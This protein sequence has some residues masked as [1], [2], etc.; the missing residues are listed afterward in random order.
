MGARLRFDDVIV[1]LPG[2]L[3]SVLYRG[4]EPVWKPPFRLGGALRGG[5]RALEDLAGDHRLL[6]DPD[7][8]DGVVATGLI[9]TPV[10]V[11]GLAKVNQYRMLR[12]RITQELD[13]VVGD[14]AVD[15]PPANY[16]EFPYDWRRDNR[17][18]AA[19]LKALVDRELPKW[20]TTR[21]YGPPP[22]VVLV[23]HSMGGLVAK[24]YLDAL[25]GW[26]RCR[27][28]VT[29]GTP[30]RG[31][32]DALGFLANGARKFGVVFDALSAV[33]AEFTSVYQLLPRYPVVLDRRADRP[34]PPDVLR[35]TELDRAPGRLDL[36]RASAAYED[37]HRRMDEDRSTHAGRPL[38]SLVSLV[39][40]VGYG[41]GT[42]QSAVLD[43]DGLRTTEE[44]L[45]LDPSQHWLATGDRTVPLLS[46]VPVEL[47]DAGTWAWENATH[48]SVHA[49]DAVLDRLVR[50]LGLYG[51]G[52]RDLQGAERAAGPPPFPAGPDAD[53]LDLRVEDAYAEDEPVV[54]TCGGL[55]AGG[56]VQEPDA[57]RI[58]FAGPGQPA[59]VTLA[60]EDGHARWTADGL[61]P[62]TYELTVTAGNRS[63]KDVFE[64]W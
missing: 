23:C 54:V 63:V 39:P 15:G 11:P 35:V 58:A 49:T 60:E 32:V 43:D 37:F 33:A 36:K 50:T 53:A 30:F 55:P 22:R 52:L 25:G 38:T 2:I 24:Y 64:V 16:F 3:G 28:L 6:D 7:H 5:G 51:S 47:S 56:P 44:P 19:R 42:L 45:A 10:A 29:F 18:T 57:P 9:G 4:E 59:A 41:H 48:S 20:A 46:A 8:D 14:S 27:A 13:V 26:E 21:P 61:V 34:G 12:R 17:V 1:V 31:A 62:G 40:V